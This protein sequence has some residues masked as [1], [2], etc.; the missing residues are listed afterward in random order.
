MVPLTNVPPDPVVEEV[1]LAYEAT[2]GTD[3]EDRGGWYRPDD[4]ARVTYAFDALRP[5]GRFLDVGLGAGQ[6]INIVAKSSL[7]DEVHGVDPTRFNKYVDL[8]GSIHRLDE[9]IDA[10]PYPDDYFDVVTCMEVLE[11]VDDEVFATGLRELRRVCRG[12]LLMSVPFDE[13]EPIYSGHRRRFSA[14]DLD[15]LFPDATFSLLYK[16]TVPWAMVEEWRG[17]TSADIQP[18]LLELD[19][20]F[21]A[22]RALAARTRVA[23]GP[24]AA[25]AVERA[26]RATRTRARRIRDVAGRS[27][28]KRKDHRRE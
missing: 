11:H 8:D 19:A 26:R 22:E 24:G 12:Q 7:F 25:A 5:G 15:A 18:R 6:F 23:S 13:P 9:G 4:W 17:P 2:H 20:R 16:L 1:R 14:A 27:G 28:L 10:L 21:G 3:P